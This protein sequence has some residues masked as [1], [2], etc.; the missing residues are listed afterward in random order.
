MQTEDFQATW[1]EEFFP[2]F[3]EQSLGQR[4]AHWFDFTFADYNTE[5]RQK[6]IRL[7]RKLPVILCSRLQPSSVGSLVLAKVNNLLEWHI[8]WKPGTFGIRRNEE[9]ENPSLLTRS[10]HSRK[11]SII[12]DLGET[13]SHGGLDP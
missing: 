7:A 10:S 6:A 1:H 8:T 11:G 4:F 3:K 13:P 9:V 5:L 12:H 2:K